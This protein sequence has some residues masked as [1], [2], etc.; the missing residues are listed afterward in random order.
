VPSLQPPDRAPRA[1]IVVAIMAAAV[2]PAAADDA[3]APPNYIAA[4][5][6]TTPAYRP[7]G[8]P[9]DGFQHDFTLNLGYGRYL[10]KTVAL[11][12]DAGPTW[13]RGDYAAFALMPAVV[14]SF[15]PRAYAAARFVVPV[16]PE[17][18]FALAPGIGVLHTFANGVSPYLEV[19]AISYVGRGDPDLAIALTAGVLFSF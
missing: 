15:N 11:E 5:V 2:I 4:L 12:L 17:T 14:W 1:S 19:N 6:T 16:D 13:I 9:W 7:P 8:G 10:T 18:H 3:Q